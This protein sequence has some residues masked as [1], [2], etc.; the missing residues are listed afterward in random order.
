MDEGRAILCTAAS[1]RTSTHGAGYPC[2]QDSGLV[3]CL[4]LCLV[5]CLV[6]E[7]T[8]PRDNILP[9]LIHNNTRTT[10]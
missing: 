2:V 1:D 7:M 3:P 4:A 8:R 10:Y 6:L 5:L 9:A